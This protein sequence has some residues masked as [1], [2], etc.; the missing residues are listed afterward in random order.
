MVRTRVTAA[1]VAVLALLAGLAGHREQPSAPGH[2]APPGHAAAPGL[3]AGLGLT[4]APA[5]AA[6]PELAAAPGRATSR[7]PPTTLAASPV[8]PTRR[9]KSAQAPGSSGA[10]ETALSVVSAMALLTLLIFV[11][12]R[13]SRRRGGQAGARTDRAPAPGPTTE[14]LA[15]QA[16]IVLVQTDEA[17]RTSEQELGFAIAR[18]GERA[19]AP[20]SA[21]LRSARAELTAAFACR[22]ALDDDNQASDATRRS[23]LSEI[24]GRCGAAS[25][26]LDEQSEAFDRLQD[27]QAR[28]PKLLAEVDAHIAQQ[29]VRISLSRQVLDH[30]A[31]KYAPEAVSMVAAN[32]DRAAS[33][34]DFAAASTARAGQDLTVRQTA[35]AATLLQAAEAAADQATDLLNAVEH[36]QAQLTQ[37][38][39][40]LPAALR[41]VDADIA[42]ARVLLAGRPDDEPASPAAR[43]H[44]VA[45]EVR[46]QQAAGP[47]D[48]LAALR[49]VQQADAAL[50]HALASVR[51]RRDKEERARAVL[52]QAMLVA[53]CSVT[54]AEDFVRTRRGSV[55]AQARTRLAEAHRHFRQAIGHASDDPEAAVTEAE[56]ADALAQQARTAAEHD[57]SASD[58]EQS[59]PPRADGFSPGLSIGPGSFGGTGT[60][61][62]HSLLAAYPAT[63]AQPLR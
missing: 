42:D 25:R 11:S 16:S 14:E 48:A 35:T 27:F 39:S 52:D 13:F 53:R 9:S 30:L 45:A 26:L 3:T 41:E 5:L 40:V 21:A 55:G 31:S 60:R 38:A 37:A 12:R 15:A 63:A 62:R 44:A 59:G 61:G 51:A 28:A 22:Q 23:S 17:V 7:E 24:T 1:F 54:A 43:A 57:I 10:G 18:V 49:D 34:L 20:F 19:A 50:D 56:R 6:A 33:R 36:V 8:R 4:A 32:P 58:K 29:T 47:F 46:A 2:A